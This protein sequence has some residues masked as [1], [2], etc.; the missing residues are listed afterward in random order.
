MATQSNPE[1]RVAFFL[2]EFGQLVRMDS[3]ADNIT[4]LRG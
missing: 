4:I 2:D 3:L 1:A